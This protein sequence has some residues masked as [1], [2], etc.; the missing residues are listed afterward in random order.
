MTA[1]LGMLCAL[2]GFSGCAHS[3]L[4]I[5]R[6][7]AEISAEVE[8]R[9]VPPVPIDE[10]AEESVDSEHQ[11]TEERST[12]QQVEFLAESEVPP[13]PVAGELSL[14]VLDA[15]SL[16]A[17]NNPRMRV[18]AFRPLEARTR[19][20]VE[21]A[22]FDPAFTA[23]AQ[24]ADAHQQ[25]SSAVQAQA[26]GVSQYNSTAI[27]PAAGLPNLAQVEKRFS[28]GTLA[29]VGVASSYSEN[30][31]NGQFLVFNP[32][33]QSAI[34]A[35]V[36]QPLLRGFG[37]D[38]NLAGIQIAQLGHQQSLAEFQ[39]ELDQ[40]LLNV[41]RAYWDAWL[42]QQNVKTLESLVD[43]AATTTRIEQKR[44]D[45]GQGSVVEAAQAKEHLETLR[46]DLEQSRQRAQT[47]SNRLKTLLGMAATDRRPL[48]LTDQPF[49]GEFEPILEDGLE[50]AIRRRAEIRTQQ[51]A[52]KQAQT[53]LSRRQNNARADVS[54]FAGYSLSGLD[55]GLGGSV[56]RLTSAEYG[57]WTMGVRFR[58]V[59]GRR[60]ERAAVERAE[61]SLQRQMRGL[62]E[63]QQQIEQ[64][65]R[66]AYDGVTTAYHV[67]ERQRERGE[68]ARVQ[69]E[70]YAKLYDAGQLDL[71]RFVR[72]RTR[73]A[74]ALQE[75]H[76]A[77]AAYN[78]ALLN[79]NY[80]VGAITSEVAP[81]DG[82]PASAS[83]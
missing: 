5:D 71:D 23:G 28:S 46:V 74:S 59:L 44:L 7:L 35:V 80:A 1:L 53:D 13:A 76:A 14:S 34:N 2:M 36:E 19:E 67:L 54:A 3:L 47:A 40:T 6:P 70:T 42:A 68:A 64:Q 38:A 72:A 27:G 30:S 41:Q 66:E 17:R 49:D 81:A 18:L 83:E 29:R 75:E 39:G 43:Q 12:I 24:W 56:D 58:H 82:S 79:W 15:V 32:A 4:T 37:S 8:Q 65:V 69:F 61:L 31:P 77:I 25:V 16:A 22:A 62:A 55:D 10:E 78:I 52:I 33:Y 21:L 20:D 26:G 51:L 60:A 9:P 73:L 50:T 63:I 57:N 48:T 45:L 11:T